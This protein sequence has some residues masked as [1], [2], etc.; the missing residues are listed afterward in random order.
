MYETMIREALA[1]LGR[2][3]TNPTHVEAY[4]RLENGTLDGLS[5]AAFRREVEISAQCVAEST[6]ADNDR[7]ARS[8][9]LCV[10]ERS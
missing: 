7:L 9:G 5:K 2:I 3:G 6:D 4:M 10:A 8:F 1:K